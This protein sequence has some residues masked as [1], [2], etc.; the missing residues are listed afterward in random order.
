MMGWGGLSVCAAV[1]GA[2]DAAKRPLYHAETIRRVTLSGANH[3]HHWGA[4]N[5][6]QSAASV[7]HPRR[8]T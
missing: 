7:D 4:L 3:G 1:T 8:G 5:H 2:G 6:S